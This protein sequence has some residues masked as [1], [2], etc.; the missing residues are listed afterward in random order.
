VNKTKSPEKH[1]TDRILGLIDG[2]T[3]CASEALELTDFCHAQ[4]AE[5]REEERERARCTECGRECTEGHAI[6]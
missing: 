4:V 5:A 3:L 2:G 1:I 6:S